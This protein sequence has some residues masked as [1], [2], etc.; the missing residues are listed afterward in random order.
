[1]TGSHDHSDDHSDHS[2]DVVQPAGAE[3][4]L[5]RARIDALLFDLPLG[6][7]EGAARRA[8]PAADEDLERHLAGCPSCAELLGLHAEL[9][10]WE[11]DQPA[12]TEL[13]DS[14]LRRRVIAALER[15]SGDDRSAAAR[16]ARRRTSRALAAA[17]TLLL[18]LAGAFAAGRLT[19][20]GGSGR[21]APG[22]LPA[23]LGDRL[24]VSEGFGD[25]LLQ[26]IAASLRASGSGPAFADAENGHGPFSF[27]NVQLRE[28][29]GDRVRLGFDYSI[30]LEVERPRT[31]PLVTEV[32]IHAILEGGSLGTQLKA[33]DAIEEPALTPRLRRAL[34]R[35]ML[36]DESAPARQAALERLLPDAAAPDVESALLDVLEHEPSV[37]MRLL[38][39][40][41]LA[42]GGVPRHRLEQAVEIGPAEPGQA[43][44][45]RVGSLPPGL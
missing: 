32:L 6:A 39:I 33:I 45:L 44:R 19:S 27:D 26:P 23:S 13:E 29:D 30:H 5:F 22:D 15:E 21:P 14:R 41:A 11:D 38:A 34:I 42:A 20:G 31:D 36:H 9:I 16:P 8:S 2:D 12:P 7:V 43:L 25:S 3:C 24:A 1:M 4:R 17:A 10:A 40:D 37:H 28:V 35:T 18:A